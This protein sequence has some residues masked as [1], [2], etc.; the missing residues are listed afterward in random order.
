MATFQHIGIKK[1]ILKILDRKKDQINQRLPTAALDAE[2]QGTRGFGCRR[3][4]ISD[5]DSRSDPAAREHSMEG[6]F[7][8][9]KSSKNVPPLSPF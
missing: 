1:K 9:C 8:T 6:C 7:L 4:T 5:W 2:R 3:K